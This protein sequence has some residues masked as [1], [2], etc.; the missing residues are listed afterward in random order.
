MR[1]ASPPQRG[2]G[3]PGLF[4][5][6][7]AHSDASPSTTAVRARWTSGRTMLPALLPTMRQ[8]RRGCCSGRCCRSTGRSP[9]T[10]LTIL[11]INFTH[12]I[13]S[14]MADV[15]RLVPL[16]GVL[17]F[18]GLGIGLRAWLHARRHGSSGIVLFR[19]NAPSERLLGAVGVVVP[20]A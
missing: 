15:W 10:H 11:K 20:A 1:L 13:R 5:L 16:A 3:C 8:W 17:V 2:R 12:A 19:G 9:G 14:R 18:F 4:H 7:A 6:T